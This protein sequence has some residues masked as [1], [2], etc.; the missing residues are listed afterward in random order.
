MVNNPTYTRSGNFYLDKEGNIVNAD[1][2]YLRKWRRDILQIPPN[3][4]SFSIGS[5]GYVSYVN[6]DGILISDW[7]N[8]NCK[9]SQ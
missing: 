6:N 1:G 2:K 7:T 8:Y 9:I 3:A 4:K 5:D